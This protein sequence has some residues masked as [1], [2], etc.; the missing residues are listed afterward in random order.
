MS[1]PAWTRNEREG[2]DV[3]AA[4]QSAVN[5]TDWCGGNAIGLKITGTGERDADTYEYVS[6]NF[7]DSDDDDDAAT[8]RLPLLRVTYDT[9]D[10]LPGE[11]C[12]PG[13]VASQAKQNKDDATQPMHRARQ[14]SR[15]WSSVDLGRD[16]DDRPTRV[17]TRFPNIAL[18][19]G[20]RILEAWVEFTARDARTEEL[21]ID[22]HGELSTDA[23]TYANKDD[24][25]DKRARTAARVDWDDVPETAP[26]QK[27]RT[28][29]VGPLV[30][31]IVD[32]GGWRSGGALALTFRHTGGDGRRR[33]YSYNDNPGLA[34][35][36]VI[37]YRDTASAPPTGPTSAGRTVTAR[38][39]M[40]SIVDSLTHYG[41][42]PTVDTFYE[43]AQYYLGGPVFFGGV[44]ANPKDEPYYHDDGRV[45]NGYGKN[46]DKG[47]LS[48]PD[49]Y[50]GG[51]R[52]DPGAQCGDDLNAEACHDE[53]VEASARYV[54]PL[55]DSC[56]TSHIVF[57]SDGEPG[58]NVSQ[59][60]IKALTGAPS[61]ERFEY[62]GSSDPAKIS[63][64]ERGQMC[65]VELADWLATTD[66]NQNVAGV[67][68]IR[69]HTIGFRLKNSDSLKRM[70][71]YGQGTHR[72]ADDALGVVEAF[73]SIISDVKAI[74]TSF[75]A[76]AATV[77][78]FNR[79]THREDIYFAMFKPDQYP[80]WDGNVKKFE[81]NDGADA[82]GEGGGEVAIR[83][84][85]RRPAVDPD[86]GFFAEN[87]RSFWPEKADDGT[88]ETEPDGDRVARGGAANQIGASGIDA[89][90]VYTY[91]YAAKDL[92]S[93]GV[94]LA[95]S[96]DYALS[97]T[98]AKLTAARL[99]IAGRGTASQVE[100]YRKGLLEWARGVDVDD[101]DNDSDHSDARRYMGDPMHSRPVIVNYEGANDKD[102]SLIY[103]ATNE[104]FLHAIDT[105]SG[106]ERFA[107]M[108]GELLPNLETFRENSAGDAHPYG[109]DGHVST[110]RVE[111][112]DDFVVERGE[113]AY[114]FVGMRRGG[115]NYYALDVSDPDA[116]RL[117]WSIQGGPGGTPGFAE[118]GQSW[119]RMSPVQMMIDGAARD[120][121][122]FGGGYDPAQ[123]PSPEELTRTHAAD[124]RGRAIFVVD[125]RTGAKLWSGEASGNAG[126][127]EDFADMTHAFPGNVRSIDL[128]RDGLVDQMYAA[129]TG[130]R[131]WR[132]DVTP[133]HESGDL[134]RGGVIAD[135]AGTAVADHRR[136]YVE[137]DVSLVENGAERFLAV[138]IGSGWRAHP[139]DEITEDRFYV[140]RQPIRPVA[141]NAY[142]TLG[143]DGEYRPVK[144]SDLVAVAGLLTPSA[145]AHGW[146]LDL[147]RTGEKVL[148]TSITFDNSVVFST[149]VPAQDVASCSTAIG[150]GRAYVLDVAD[151]SPL[152]DLDGDDDVDLDDQSV[153]LK[154]G[155]IPPEAMILITEDG[156]DVPMILFGGERLETG[157]VNRTQR[158]F[159]SDMGTNV[160]AATGSDEEPEERPGDDTDRSVRTAEEDV[161]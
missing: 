27:L 32:Q 34:P 121:L 78:Q 6:R 138:S 8:S 4:V 110:W 127:S 140:M 82:N 30:Q 101:A 133:Y 146:Y 63:E 100:S 52:V 93:G 24:E 150:G 54:S 118:L 9:D 94:A 97:E 66:H 57:V 51:A 47:R 105:D 109:L 147:S 69:T 107:F 10:L 104:G 135:L 29:D 72:E 75:T 33:L 86:T 108:P 50:T 12:M 17:G 117:A 154:H 142:G 42:T 122:V 102:R 115:D 7:A 143:A 128:D 31:E 85:D 87:A 41:D 11:G 116:P 137:P 113:S 55:G 95:S 71:T 129:D 114:V 79:L 53:Y 37:R 13:T 153:E 88:V 76:P 2:I 73:D 149:Y 151:G 36:L 16:G 62:T 68:S 136:F 139:L 23:R 77:N 144:E 21:D 103:V 125:A 5:D 22:V 126:A 96:D 28:P 132:F 155:G 70:S 81:V 43:A 83:G 45:N 61:C 3:T 124:A 134:V 161:R 80:S 26:D 145:N 48:H 92:P 25:I 98:N 65:A 46:L 1:V 44:R 112:D 159:W 19:R 67:Q 58:L 56:Q 130:G 160:D 18:E 60:E 156:G 40:L 152:R 15:A 20:A 158:T 119:S 84:K 120:V 131:I 89:R 59:G 38:E 64:V 90:T 123:D 157:I 14:Q 39:Q 141:E 99:G 74:D 106:E 35:K 49:S 148:G 91:P 111:T